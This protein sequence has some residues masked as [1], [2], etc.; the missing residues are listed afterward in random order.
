MTKH[1][2]IHNLLAT[3]LTMAA[4]FAGQQAF[5][6]RKAVTYTITSIELNSSTNNYD[7]V[8]TRSG[9]APFDAS[10]PTTYT[11][12]VNKL[13][14]GQNGN[15]GQ[16]HVALA[17]GFEIYASWNSGSD[18]SFSNNC[19]QSGVS[20][21]PITYAVSNPNGGYYVTRIV[22]QG[23]D[24][25]WDNTTYDF[26]RPF[27]HNTS[28]VRP[29]GS[30]TL[31]YYDAIPENIGS[32]Q[33]N[34]L[35]EA[36][37]IN[38]F[39]H[40]QELAEYVNGEY[41]TDYSA[42][43]YYTYVVKEPHNCTGL[44][45]RQTADIDFEPTSAW[46]DYNSD[47]HNL[48]AIGCIKKGRSPMGTS[49]TYNNYFGGTYDGQGH[50]I[51]GIR[52]HGNDAYAT[53]AYLGLFGFVKEGTVQN[54]T[55]ANARIAGY[56][57]TGGIVG[58]NT[59]GSTVSNCHAAHDVAI[60][61]A[62]SNIS[63]V[64]GIVGDNFYSSNVTGCTSA[65]VITAIG[66][67][68]CQYFGGI[69][70]KNGSGCT[71]SN[72]TAAGVIVPSYGDVTRTGA[73]VGENEG[74]LTGNTYHSCLMGTT[75]AFNIGTGVGNVAGT[76]LDNTKLF[77]YDD[78]DN[79][80]LINA[81][82]NSTTAYGGTAPSV[83][84]LTITLK[85]RTLY[86]DGTW[87]T[88][89]LPFNPS[90][91]GYYAGADI[92]EMDNSANGGTAFDA[93]TGTLT[94][95]FKTVSTITKG[96][97]YIIKWT[98]G[99]DIVDPTF[100]NVDGSR[101]T[102]ST[103]IV[104][105]SDN[106]VS[107]CGTYGPVT[108]TDGKLL[109]AHNADNRGFHCYM[110][111]ASPTAPDNYAF[112]GWYTDNALTTPVTALPFGTDGSFNL[113]AKFNPA[114]TVTGYGTGNGG[115]HLIASPVAGSI[116]PSAVENI[117]NET[118]YDLYRL[119]PSNTMWENYK[120]ATHQSDFRL[121]NGHGYLYATK[122]TKTL[123]FTGAFN[124]GSSKVVDLEQGWNLVGN[125]FTVDAYVNRPF[126]KMNDDGTGIV[127]VEN[128][129]NYTTAQTIPACTGI[130]VKA[131]NS[132]ESVIFSTTAPTLAAPNNGHIQMT[133]AQTVTTRD[134]S[135]TETLDNAIVSFNEGSQLGK[136]YFGEQNGN[137]YIPQ[138][139]EE[140][141]IVCSDRQGEM[142]VCF[143]AR[144]NGSYTITVN[145]EGVTFGYLHLIDNMTGVDVDLLQTPEYTFTTK[146]TDYESRFK[147]VF[148]ANGNDNENFAFISNGNLIVNG[149]GTLQVIDIIGR[150]LFT[151]ELSTFNSSLSTLNFTPG[152]YVLQLINGERVRTQ[153][154]V[155][156]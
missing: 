44:T 91:M 7:I 90:L 82:A 130:V 156:E 55:I 137:I 34:R 25:T 95:N 152:V 76:T 23:M 54:V 57:S 31:T 121:V 14:F 67:T 107:L 38:C 147:L 80:A 84:S 9:D 16:F 48:F 12:S 96:W 145:P 58:C 142:P 141:A 103:T 97:P 101:M 21:K 66:M 45:F 78:R 99:N 150:T 127:A 15:P 128:Y 63:G 47:E 30:L 112:G 126:Y 125:P 41:G 120:N 73:I 60:Y 72:C 39:Q 49:T 123:A 3:L 1:L 43:S 89:C 135:S 53:N 26:I 70:G 100:S 61:A 65:A 115:W 104:K 108:P 110:T 4:L 155:M 102:A 88:L 131:N 8:F 68:N 114:L 116:E 83:N 149:E 113:Y 111:L 50:T 74:T 129:D 138:G 144:E 87:N 28:T 36:Y 148:N 140:Y 139:G 71:V 92:M 119:N 35:L 69:V 118:E 18:V 13:S 27:A 117:F 122:E 6:A 75:H 146:T 85:G 79:T 98:S 42:Y 136:F 59:N 64:G 153:K 154:I 105:S 5:A 37:E 124:T 2:S 109:D 132:G 40:L 24:Y 29:F 19:I 46:D 151:K 134:G 11:A 94:I 93:T 56:E 51:S 86:K 33:Y 77:L 52:I 10:A 32:I 62:Y 22:M 81:Y 106:Y 143:K 20:E 17:D 133:L